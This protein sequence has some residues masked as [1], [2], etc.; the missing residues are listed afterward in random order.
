MR[1]LDASPSTV[2]PPPTDAPTASKTEAEMQVA[3]ADRVLLNKV[4]LV[5]PRS[6]QDVLQR[7]RDINCMA[8]ISLCTRCRVDLDSLLNIKAFDATK[9]T[10]VTLPTQHHD[11]HHHHDHDHDHGDDHCGD[12]GDHHDHDHNH[13]HDHDHH[14]DHD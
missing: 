8:K 4:D 12:H 1:H 14:H 3:Y 5:S 7:L 10:A 13:D 2:V 6:V 9:H 11:H